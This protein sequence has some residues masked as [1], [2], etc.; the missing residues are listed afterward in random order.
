[1]AQ[2]AGAIS[3]FI[4]V[5]VG[6][7]AWQLA[8]QGA[9]GQWRP[10]AILG[11]VALSYVLLA[12][13]F[14]GVFAPIRVNTA[15]LLS[16]LC[17]VTAIVL[18]TLYWRNYLSADPP[19][20]QRV[21]VARAVYGSVGVV[22]VLLFMTSP[23]QPDG[24]GFAREFSGNPRMQLYWAVQAIVVIHAMSTLAGAAARAGVR[25]RHWRGLRFSVV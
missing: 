24:L 21:L 6:A 8:P 3:V 7:L 12:P 11:L 9:R 25:A 22:L 5:G 4:G 17:A 19:T 2:F 10:V 13:A 16:N 14:Q 20:R 23:Q 15:Y 18:T 1:V